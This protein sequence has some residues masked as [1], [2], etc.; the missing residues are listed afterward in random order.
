MPRSG[1]SGVNAQPLCWYR[2]TP[3]TALSA[4]VDAVDIVPACDTT[5]YAYMEGGISYQFALNTA[6][7]GAFEFD[8]TSSG[9]LDVSWIQH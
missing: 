7:C 5:N 4:T 6:M 1:L 3:G 9:T 2:F 8:H